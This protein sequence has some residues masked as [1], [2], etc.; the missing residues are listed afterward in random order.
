MIRS[1]FVRYADWT[2]TTAKPTE[3]GAY[4]VRGFRLDPECRGQK[5][6]VEV[7]LDRYGV[8]CCNLHESNSED[9]RDE[10]FD[11]AALD[12]TFEWCGPLLQVTTCR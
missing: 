10:W 4:W 9:D 2:W 5:A 3:P 6:L 11:V 7:D 12:P 1:A 8:L